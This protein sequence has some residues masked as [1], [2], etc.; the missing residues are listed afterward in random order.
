M[1]DTAGSMVNVEQYWL[2]IKEYN[3]CFYMYT[4]WSM[5]LIYYLSKTNCNNMNAAST[6][7]CFRN[8]FWTYFIF[9]SLWNKPSDRNCKYN[10]CDN[11]NNAC[12]RS[13]L[14]IKRK[15]F[16]KRVRGWVWGWG[17]TRL[18]GTSDSVETQY[19]MIILNVYVAL[20]GLKIVT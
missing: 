15:Y 19:I 10:V 6:N 8:M 2:I 5:P 3:S 17:C 4:C 14:W 11:E 7:I 12:S 9:H 20:N 13:Y 18:L 16:Q 1:K